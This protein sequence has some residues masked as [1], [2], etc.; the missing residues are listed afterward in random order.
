MRVCSRRVQNDSVSYDFPYFSADFEL[1][2]LAKKERKSGKKIHF[3]L[4]GKVKSI[5]TT[6]RLASIVYFILRSVSLHSSKV[7]IFIKNLRA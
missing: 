1:L 5:G 7:Q 6:Y 4:P 3:I 2:Y